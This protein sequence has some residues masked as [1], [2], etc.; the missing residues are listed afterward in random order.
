MH[1]S[2]D[3]TEFWT[4]LCAASSDSAECRSE[5]RTTGQPAQNAQ[6]AAPN[7]TSTAWQSYTPSSSQQSTDPAASSWQKPSQSNWK[8]N[9][10][11][12]QWVMK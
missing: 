1:N 11:T 10:G 6:G 5:L 4:K 7:A 2:S 8:L 9:S 3:S 12:Q